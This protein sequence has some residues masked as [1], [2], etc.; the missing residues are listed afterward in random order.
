MNSRKTGKQGKRIRYEVET[1]SNLSNFCTINITKTFWYNDVKC[2]PNKGVISGC[3]IANQL[4]A[5]MSVSDGVLGVKKILE[6]GRPF[7]T[8]ELEKGW[9]GVTYLPLE[10]HLNIYC[11]V[12]TWDYKAWLPDVTKIKNG[13]KL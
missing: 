6:L 4:L 12:I 5:P 7:T 13:V 3:Y 2:N 11:F 8:E 10:Q 9:K 1:S